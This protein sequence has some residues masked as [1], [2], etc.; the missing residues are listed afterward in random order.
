MKTTQPLTTAALHAQHA[1][2]ARVELDESPAA[3]NAM[4]RWHQDEL[5]RTGHFES[6]RSMHAPHASSPRSPLAALPGSGT[7]ADAAAMHA[8]RA[9]SPERPGL[10]SSRKS[11]HVIHDDVSSEGST[12]SAGVN[13]LCSH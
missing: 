6:P 13:S 7:A 9:I 12:G 3:R 1:L 10:R 11:G 8:R 4:E 5:N 2:G